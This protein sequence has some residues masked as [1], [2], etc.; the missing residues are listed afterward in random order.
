VRLEG[1]NQR[2]FTLITPGNEP[3]TFQII[4]QCLNLDISG[5]MSMPETYLDLNPYLAKQGARYII[6]RRLYCPIGHSDCWIDGKVA[7]SFATF[8]TYDHRLLCFS[9][10][11]SS[12]H[13]SHPSTPYPPL[14]HSTVK[15][16]DGN[17]SV[18]AN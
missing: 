5:E 13:I 4:A 1:L 2:K 7:L 3:A 14:S 8:K 15:V 17:I 18:E 10:Y 12:S 16:D 6:L 11:T 9:L